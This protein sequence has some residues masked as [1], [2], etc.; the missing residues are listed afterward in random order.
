MTKRHW[1]AISLQ[2]KAWQERCVA[3]LSSIR[4]CG[5]LTIVAAAALVSRRLNSVLLLMR[6]RRDLMVFT[7]LLVR[8]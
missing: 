6:G 8:Q 1:R 4:N 5:W 2:V 3:S 7:F